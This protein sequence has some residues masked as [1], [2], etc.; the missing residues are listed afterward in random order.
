MDSLTPLIILVVI[1]FVIWLL[2]GAEEAKK[3]E[4]R[5][6][7]RWSA[8]MTKKEEIMSKVNSE[9]KLL[10]DSM[11]VWDKVS[12]F[13][14][15][16]AFDEKNLRLV[17][18]NKSEQI[19]TFSKGDILKCELRENSKTLS[20]GETTKKNSIPRAIVGGVVAGG[21][22]AIVGGMST[23][24]NHKTTT[25]T[26][27]TYYIDFYTK[28]SKL[29][30]VT[31][32]GLEEQLRK[33]YSFIMLFVDIDQKKSVKEEYSVADEILKLKELLDNQIITDSEFNAEKR[34]V[35]K[36]N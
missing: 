18:V 23:K 13:I 35:L 1:F 24:E 27:S 19:F 6:K 36:K 15:A 7:E 5:K 32:S 9:L 34:K 28:N 29:P 2:H 20:F 16:L 22:G 10:T 31:I 3:R 33:W 25:R 11:F 14:M 8:R 30:Y 12:K 4:K 26:I 21:S 17:V